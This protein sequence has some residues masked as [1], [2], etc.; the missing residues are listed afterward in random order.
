MEASINETREQV[1]REIARIIPVAKDTV[2]HLTK[3]LR[4]GVNK[5]IAEVCQLRDQSLEAGKEVGRY[6]EVPES[7]AWLKELLALT[8]GEN[9]I[10][11]KR[12]R[13]IVLLVLRGTATWLT[14]NEANNSS[15]SNLFF[16]LKNLITELERWKV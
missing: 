6:Q 5:A 10:E 15:V 12:V 13:T 4:N 3:E 2:N 7:S 8:G 14:H 1:G 16:T 11:S 9:N